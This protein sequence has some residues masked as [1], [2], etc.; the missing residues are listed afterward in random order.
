MTAAASGMEPVG[1]PDGRGR[2]EAGELYSIA[3]VPPV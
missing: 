3:G 1:A 2:R